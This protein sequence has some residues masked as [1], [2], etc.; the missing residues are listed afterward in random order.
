MTFR[1]PRTPSELKAL[2]RILE[3]KEF[4]DISRK[5]TNR[6][7]QAFMSL[8]C[9]LLARAFSPDIIKGGFRDSGVYPFKPFVALEQVRGIQTLEKEEG[10]SVAAAVPEVVELAK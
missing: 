8:D 10:L 6:I 1:F 7:K 2:E 5:T 3:A 4:E 9:G